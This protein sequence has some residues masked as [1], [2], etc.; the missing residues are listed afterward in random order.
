M[1]TLYQETEKFWSDTYSGRPIAILNRSS[2][3][4]VYL[5]HV[6]QHN[7]RFETAEKAVAWLVN[8]I[9]EGNLPKRGCKPSRGRTRRSIKCLP[10]LADRLIARA[11]RAPEYLH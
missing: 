2:G 7:T 5:D 9:D 4:H 8:R 6:L 3:W 1:N 10:A 11:T